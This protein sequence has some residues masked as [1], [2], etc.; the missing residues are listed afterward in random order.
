T[1]TSQPFSSRPLPILSAATSKAPY[2]AGIPR[3]PRMA[4]LVIGSW[5]RLISCLPDEP[6]LFQLGKAGLDAIH[7]PL[8]LRPCD[9]FVQTY[10]ERS[11]CLEAQRLARPCGITDAVTD[12]AGPI[13]TDEHRL[14]FEP[15]TSRERS[16]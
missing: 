2:L 3:E 13:L 7:R 9:Q 6:L 10:F 1:V 14:G 4:S 5:S 12:V 11:A 8:T 16:A 15:K